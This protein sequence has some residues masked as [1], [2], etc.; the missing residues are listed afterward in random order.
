MPRTG[1][2]DLRVFQQELAARLASKT[3]AQVESSR[4]GLAAAGLQ[5]LVRLADAGEVIAMPALASVPL[6]KPWFLG[7][8][9]IRGNLY[10]V[11]D[12]A[13][14]L[15]HP[16]APPLAPGG[17]SRLVLFGPRTGDLRVGIVVPRVLGLRNLAELAPGV[18]PTDAPPWYG[19]RWIDAD[20][21]PWQEVD[22]VALAR[23]PAFLQV[24]R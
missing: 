14:F 20:G 18:P 6:T 3:A 22:L 23:D 21:A 17:T 12:F 10:G 24:G 11:V 16:V 13:G 15:G 9:N 2:L 1:K 7:V 19:R 4:L 8:A 5:W